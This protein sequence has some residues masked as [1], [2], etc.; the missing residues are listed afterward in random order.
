MRT[1]RQ[2]GYALLFASMGA[3]AA[4]GWAQY[5][6]VR[7]PSTI[8]A[9]AP[10]P[11]TDIRVS[12]APTGSLVPVAPEVS[13]SGS[14]LGL[15]AFDP[16]STTPTT[17]FQ[18][19]Y[20]PAPTYTPYAST[21]PSLGSP[22]APAGTAGIGTGMT[23]V[24]PSTVTVPPPSP[25]GVPS[26]F[27]SSTPNSLFPNGMMGPNGAVNGPYG[28]PLRLIQNPG[29]EYTYVYGETGSDVAMNDFDTFL[30]VA[31]P[32]FLWSGQPIF[33]TPEFDLT[34]LDGPQPPTMSNLPPQVYAGILGLAWKTN[35]N[36][37]AGLD[38]SGSAGVYS[39]FES[40][41]TDSVRLLGTALITA[42]LTP[43]MTLKG[44]VTY[45]DRLDVKLL[46]AGGLLWEPNPQTRFDIYFPRP[47]LSQFLSTV[48]TTDLWWFIA[49]EYGGGSWTM[50]DPGGA[51]QRVDINDY[52]VMGGL[53]FHS[54]RG[55]K[56]YIEAG[57]V[58]NREVLYEVTP[59][60]NFDP[61]D[62]F[63]VGGGLVF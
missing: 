61:G 21:P 14:T 56:G 17:V 30:S 20:T 54:H 36:N 27:P 15:P 9:I 31:F 57:Y 38:L 42:R 3:S 63:L 45:L 24:P 43:T 53:E 58:W 47:R 33:V 5:N 1:L 26:A 13:A 28:A 12:Q 34:L 51:F 50:S 55:V 23:P 52:R 59:S 46:P 8:G 32:N 7:Q 10:P 41:N 44:G 37:V 35:P 2:I 48:G 49:G 22:P 16:Y 6:R 39:D 40:V 4:T 19:S 29:F 60:Q 62:T 25:Y 11:P 18:P